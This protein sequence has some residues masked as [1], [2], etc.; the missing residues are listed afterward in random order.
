MDIRGH[1]IDVVEDTM[2]SIRLRNE[3]LE[4]GWENLRIG[5][6]E[7][8]NQRDILNE[9]TKLLQVILYYAY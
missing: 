2:N 5:V 9:E 4:H 6:D 8:E 1:R 7:L 3:S